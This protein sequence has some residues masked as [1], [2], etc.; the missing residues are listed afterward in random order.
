MLTLHYF[1]GSCALASHLALEHAGATYRLQLVDFKTNQQATAEYAKVNP[2]GRVPALETPH[3]VITE[4]PAVL[5]Y[6]AQIH[7][8]ADLLP[9]D[10]AYL[11]AKAN[12]FNSYLCSTV[13]VAHAHGRRASRWADDPAAQASMAS[14]VASNM[15]ACFSLIEREGLQGPW[16]LGQ[17]FSICDYY[18][19]TLTSWLPGH[20]VAVEQFPKVHR[21]HLEILQGEVAGRVMPHHQATSPRPTTPANP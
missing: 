11:W 16:V 14:K 20:G 4:S 1:P 15:T 12:E 5:Q 18:L 9:L 8:A 6:I 3:G 13:H 7:P 17:R 21:H 19:F 10:D 2:K